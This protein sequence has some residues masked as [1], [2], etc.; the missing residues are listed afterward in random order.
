MNENNDKYSA[1]TNDTQ[2]DS[3]Q[4]LKPYVSPQGTLL[5]DMDIEGGGQSMSESLSADGNLS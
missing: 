1:Q 4:K 2:T 3:I 5:I